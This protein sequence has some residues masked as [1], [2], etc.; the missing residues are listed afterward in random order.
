MKTSRRT[1]LRA[2][3][4]GAAAALGAPTAATSADSASDPTVSR[5]LGPHGDGL[6]I[7]AAGYLYERVRPLI[8]RSWAG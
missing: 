5:R 4:A 8:C 3:T 1:F 7:T 2:G 6:P